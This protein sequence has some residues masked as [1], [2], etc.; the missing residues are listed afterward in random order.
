MLKLWNFACWQLWKLRT[1]TLWIFETLNILD[2]DMLK[3]LEKIWKRRG[4]RNLDDPSEKFLDILDMGSIYSR[5]HKKVICHHWNIETLKRRNVET[6]KRRNQET[7]KPRNKE[8]KKPRS[9]EA[10]KWRNQEI[11]E[12][13]N[14]FWILVILGF[15][16]HSQIAT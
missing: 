12:P 16:P 10:K 5:K 4:Q 8:A 7:W 1:L 6:K 9:Q 15:W 2:T 11:Q 3:L 13:R 14:H